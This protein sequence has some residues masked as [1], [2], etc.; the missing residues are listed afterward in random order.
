MDS[1]IRRQGKGVG[2]YVEAVRWYRL[3]AG[4]GNA[5]AKNNLGAM[6]EVGR[7]VLHNIEEALRLYAAAANSGIVD[8]R[9]NLVR[10]NERYP[11]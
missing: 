11:R 4:Q 7:G 1:E 5:D 2:N 10:L 9:E 3:S 6:Y 8:A